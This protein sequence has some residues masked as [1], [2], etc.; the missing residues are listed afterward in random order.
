MIIISSVL[1]LSGIGISIHSFRP[2]SARVIAGK[3]ATNVSRELAVIDRDA[4]ILTEQFAEQNPRQLSLSVTYPFYLYDS[5]ALIYWTDSKYVPPVR[6]VMGNFTVRFIKTAGGD[7]LAKKW[8]LDEHRF[9]VALLPL[10]REYTIRNDYLSPQWNRKI[11]PEGNVNILDSNATLG[12]PVCVNEECL[13]KISFLQDEYTAHER[14]RWTAIAVISAGILFLILFVFRILVV[15][16]RFSPDLGFL[17]L[18]GCLLV[19]RLLMIN[20]DFPSALIQLPL[21]DPKNFASSSLNPSLGDLLLNE[22][23]L[24]AICYYLFMHY[25]RFRSIQWIYKFKT[26]RSFLRIV[27]AVFIFFSMLFPFVVVQT[28]YNNSSVVLDISHS[29]RFD[30]FRLAAMAALLIAWSCSFLFAHVFI[31]MVVSRRQWLAVLMYFFIGTLIFVGVNELTGQVYWTTVLVATLYFILVYALR[32]YYSLAKVSYATFAYLF[33]AIVGFSLNSTLSIQHHSRK[34]KVEGQ[35][36]FAG[37]FL[38]DRDYFGEYLLKE[39]AAKIGRDAFIQTRMTSPF[40]NKE[41]VR[42]KVRQVFLPSYFNKYDVDIFLFSSSGLPYDNHITLTFS[43]LINT[44]NAMGAFKTE[45]GVYFVNSPSSDISQRYLVVVPLSKA[46]IAAGYVVLELL[47][48][49]IIPENVYPELLVDNR[50]QQFYRAQDYSYA[51]FSHRSLLFSSGDFNYERFF[52]REWLGDPAI[53]LKGVRRSGFDHIAVEDD[54]SRVAV[55]SSPAMPLVYVTA[56]FSFLIVA[57]LAVLLMLILFQGIIN[58]FKG[59]TMFFSARIQLFINLAFFLPLIV[60]SV[61]TL[62]LTSLSSLEQLNTEYLNKSR[63]FGGQVASMLDEYNRTAN[64]N[65]IEFENQLTDLAKLSNLDASVYGPLGKLLASSQPLIFENG[66]ISEYINPEA[67]NKIKL[68]ENLFISKEKVGNLDYYVSYAAL[69]SPQS[70]RLIGVLT[71][72]FFQS[73]SSLEKIQIT[74]LANML[75]VFAGF[76]IVLLVLSYIGS[77]W[78]TFPLRYITQSLSRTSLTKVNQPLTWRANDEIGLMVKEYNQMLYKLSESKAELEK[79]QRER[80]WREIAQQVAHEI[81]NP[82][83]PMK[84][85]LQQ[86]ERSLRAGADIRDKTGKALPSLLSQVDTLDEIASSFSSFAKM[87]DPE[88]QRLQLN[89]L[90][91]RIVTL[92]SQSGTILFRSASREIFVMADEQ[93][94]GR[95]FSNLILNAFQ[96]ARAGV[97][98]QVEVH[99]AHVA[100]ACL[101]TFKDNGKGIDRELADRVFIPHFSTKKSGS[102]LGLAISKQGIEQMGGRIW[103]ESVEGEGTS[104]FI[105]LPVTD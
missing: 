45:Y 96:A 97:P 62:S 63:F 53:H 94:L 22:M 2:A 29:L 88:I 78:L 87:P 33:A 47:L 8:P 32:L 91:K 42:Q 98:A 85:T 59:N 80:A 25:F 26:G 72:P 20:V 103:F 74:I 46:D 39:V 93:L 44:Y 5:L 27:S 70:G 37:N 99:V 73:L 64:E 40:L 15:I 83:T 10:Y 66:L 34:E 105:E 102:G 89:I 68:G 49:K 95:I 86:L 71:I 48:K 79:T 17:F 16:R 77:Q 41:A 61:T 56:N 75:N 12:T 90:L 4:A 43:E 84:L 58:H 76:F 30:G 1:L 31:R 52:K 24:F 100:N 11:F 28:I 21:F 82:L 54:N 55:V 35:F 9:L 7:F 57:G 67:L 92:H 13:F 36:R 81:K 6:Q 50:F 65:R 23:A 69:K 60:V 104:F 14:T 38:I 3:V 18:S 51:V 19:I 101:I